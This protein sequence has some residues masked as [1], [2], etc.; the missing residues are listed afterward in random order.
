MFLNF[1]ECLVLGFKLG[2][3][4]FW[5]LKKL[6]KCVKMRQKVQKCARNAR[7]SAL[8]C[9]KVLEKCVFLRFCALT[10][11][12]QRSEWT[13]AQRKELAT[14]VTEDPEKN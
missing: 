13:K 4:W 6:E 14:E 7:K 9:K 3:G 10:V 12:R 11:K 5:G 1:W 2:F 8:F